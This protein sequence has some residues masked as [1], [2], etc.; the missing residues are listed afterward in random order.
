MAIVTVEVVAA[1][2]AGGATRTLYLSTEAFTTGA[3]DTPASTS[4]DA[5][6]LD[7]GNVGVSLFGDG[8]TGGASRLSLGEIRVANADGRYD[9]WL[10]YGFDG[11]RVVIRAGEAGAAYPAG[12]DPVFTGTVE[13]LTVTRAEVVIRLR[14]S[15]LLFSLPVL[16]RVYGGTNVLPNGVDGTANDLAGKRKPRLYGRAFN[17][18]APVVNTAKL[19]YQ[20][21]DGPIASIDGV[22]DR[23]GALTAGTDHANNGGLQGAT[24][25]AG[26]YQTCL[27]EGLF[28]LGSSPAGEITADATQ[29]ASAVD[30]TAASILSTLALAA[31]VA[32]GDVSGSDVA[33][34]AADVPAELGVWISEDGETYAKVMDAVAASVGGFYTFDPAGVFRVGRLAE[35]AGT[36]VLD[37]YDY[38]VADPFERRPARD[39]DV[40]AKGFTIRHS[41]VFRVQAGDIAGSVT[42]ARRALIANEYRAQRAANEAVALKFLLAAEESVDTLLTTQADASNE[43]SRRLA[44]HGVKRDFFDVNID[45]SLLTRSGARL[46][47]T[48]RLT[49][50]RFGLSSGRLFRLLGTRID[51]A[52]NRA[53]LT[54]W[55]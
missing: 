43:A 14:D 24:V 40:P 44:L 38:D 23:G 28:R 35:P 55:G 31:G 39:G 7:P 15:Q 25:G 27:A 51:R 36:P 53:T 50:G 21:S 26:T 29:G 5:S 47:D 33:A 20:V 37:L 11:R 18:P 1:I 16:T 12:F 34:L 2:D 49:V 9:G 54:L 6:L 17:I 19:I 48:V 41:R 46:A 42:A 3:G 30:R 32:S 8:R 10:N 4:F 52:R 22:Y 45:A 13:T